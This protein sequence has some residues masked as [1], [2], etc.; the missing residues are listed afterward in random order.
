MSS[1]SDAAQLPSEPLRGGPG[2]HL[3]DER[4]LLRREA[5]LL[6][7][8][9]GFAAA[10]FLA[11]SI[12]ESMVLD[13]VEEETR[14]ALTSLKDIL[15]PFLAAYITSRVYS[16]LLRRY[17]QQIQRQRRLLAHIIDTSADGIITL[18]ARDRITTWNRGAEQIFGYRA[19]EALGE[20]ASILYPA[21]SPAVEELARLRHAVEDEG[22]LPSHTGIRVRRDGSEMSVEFSTTV[23]RDS[24]GRYAGRASIFRDVS[25]RE[26]LAEELAQQKS[27]AAVGEMA[28]A[29]AHE[30]KNP[31]AGIAGAVRV[32]GKEFPKDDPRAEV[33]EEVQHQVKR[34][35]E[36][37]R[38]LLTFARPIEPRFRDIDVKEF[39][40]RIL[41]VLGEEPVLKERGVRVEAP[42]GLTVLAD[43]QLLENTLMNLMLN[44]G[45]AMGQSEGEIVVRAFAEDGAT[46]LAVEDTGVG[47]P[48]DV[49]PHL[50]KPFFTT[51]AKGTGLGLTI[52]HKFV[53]LMGG[54]VEVDSEP[55]RGATFTV[56]LPRKS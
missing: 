46:S 3:E 19:G 55:G 49:L 29:V 27:L 7:F 22:V 40:E 5:F 12:I 48:P 16:N 47:I 8:C 36:A 43:P 52:V 32:I 31:L 50:F 20:H 39:L 9:A 2:S 14:T 28:A 17:G 41:R 56:V 4:T 10:L 45:Q 34:L 23:L 37:I 42:D 13:G 38:N 1:V 21:G 33:V 15:A 25:E 18:D 6:I 51:R 44:A 26:R 53:E 24:H 54:R 11:W 30:I 35:D